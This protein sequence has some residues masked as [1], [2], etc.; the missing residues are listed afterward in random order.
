EMAIAGGADAII[1]GRGII[2]SNDPGAEAKRYRNAGWN[3][4]QS[5]N[6]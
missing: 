3:A 1:V 4:F 6:K 5:M 2:A